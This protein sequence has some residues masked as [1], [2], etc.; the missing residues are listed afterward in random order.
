MTIVGMGPL[1]A[2]LTMDA[3]EQ[4]AVYG[5]ERREYMLGGRTG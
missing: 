2:L 4:T 3:M 1:D 5:V